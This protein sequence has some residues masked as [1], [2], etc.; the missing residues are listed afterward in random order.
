MS[1]NSRSGNDSK[2]IWHLMSSSMRSLEPSDLPAGPGL[3]GFICSSIFGL[4]LGLFPVKFTFHGPESPLLADLELQ[5]SG[6]NTPKMGVNHKLIPTH[7]A[8]PAASPG[9]AKAPGSS[10]RKAG[11]PEDLGWSCRN[12]IFRQDSHP[13]LGGRRC[14]IPNFWLL[15]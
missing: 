10:F 5:K 14:C 13:G 1:R 11:N 12:S 2:R 6:P 7:P 4:F 9:S 15:C 3:S 8:D